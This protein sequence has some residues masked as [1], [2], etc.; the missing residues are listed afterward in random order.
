MHAVLEVVFGKIRP[1]RFLVMRSTSSCSFPPSIQVSLTWWFWHQIGPSMREAGRYVVFSELF[2]FLFPLLAIPPRELVILA[3]ANKVICCEVLL[4]SPMLLMWVLPRG[5]FGGSHDQ[6]SW[7]VMC[8]CSGGG[9]VIWVP[10]L[11]GCRANSCGLCNLLQGDGA[12]VCITCSWNQDVL[13][14]KG[15]PSLP[16]LFLPSSL[17]PFTPLPSLPSPPSSSILSGFH[18]SVH[19]HLPF[20]PSLLLFTTATGTVCVW[21]AKPWAG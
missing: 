13:A 16:L 4:Q 14:W 15:D 6:H 12:C 9:D 11:T 2:N 10:S 3:Q 21:L 1:W 7:A 20:E 19:T 18:S 17:P 8:C 5:D